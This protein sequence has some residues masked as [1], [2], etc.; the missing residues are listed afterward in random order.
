MARAIQQYTYILSQL[1][2]NGEFSLGL[3]MPVK[4]HKPPQ[5]ASVRERS[6]KPQTTYSKRMVRNC[7]AKLERSHGKHN[8]AF[9]TYTLP[10]LPAHD[11]ENL[12]AKSGV[13][14]NR[15]CQEIKRNQERAGIKSEIVWIV[16]IQQ[17]RLKR[18]GIPVIHFHVV[19]Q[20]RKS[21]YH[22]YAISKEQN[23][24]IWNRIVS[25]A[26]GYEIE[27]PSAANIQQIKKSAENYMSKYMSK[28]SKVAVDIVDKQEAKLLPKNWWGATFSLR[29]WVKQNT[30]LLAD[31]A[32]ELIKSQYKSSINNLKDSLFTWL[33]AHTIKLLEPHGEEIEVPVTIV[34]KVKRNS[35]HLFETKTLDDVPMSWEW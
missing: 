13:I 16:E 32:K 1:Y 8:L 25:N 11:L 9:A 7:I 17:E 31:S 30:K 21:R 33:F 3:S 19:F 6:G 35:I 4:S 5:S 29:N 12:S 15:L 23:T 28:S 20:S 24:R 14:A 22:S 26:L 34:G 18:T 27:M 2:P 10:D